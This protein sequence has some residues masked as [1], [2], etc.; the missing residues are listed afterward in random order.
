[1]IEF[2][3]RGR[4]SMIRSPG[5]LVRQIPNCIFIILHQLKM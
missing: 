1:M 4:Y 3:H 2:Y 5:I